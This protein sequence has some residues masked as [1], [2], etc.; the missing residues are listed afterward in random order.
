MKMKWLKLKGGLLGAQHNG[1]ILVAFELVREKYKDQIPV[2][3]TT[4]AVRDCSI[5]LSLLGIR[6]LTLDLQQWNL[7]KPKIMV[8]GPDI[9]DTPASCVISWT[10]RPP[11]P[12]AMG[13]HNK[14]WTKSGRSGFEFFKVM[15]IPAR[16]PKACV[17]DPNIRFLLFAENA[18]PAIDSPVAEGR[19][20]LIEDMP[21][22]RPEKAKKTLEALDAYV[23]SDVSDAQDGIA[24]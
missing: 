8:L 9:G 18:D 15:H 22:G 3:S 13:D 19:F 17:M 5:S 1:D 12:Y 4:P 11:N 10:R 16:L 2:R 6:N 14:K 7:G 23:D 21:W 20:S 24:I